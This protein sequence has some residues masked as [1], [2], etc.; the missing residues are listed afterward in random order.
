MPLSYILCSHSLPPDLQSNLCEITCKHNF[1]ILCDTTGNVKD[2]KWRDVRV[3]DILEVRDNEDFPADLLCLACER[4]DGVAYIKTTNLDG[5]HFPNFTQ[6]QYAV[7]SAQEFI[8]NSL[9]IVSVWSRR[10]F[11]GAKSIQD[12]MSFIGFIWLSVGHTIVSN[13]LEGK[14]LLC[15]SQLCHDHL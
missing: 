11:W 10:N 15:T 3:G 7:R 5:D 14:L 1:N 12:F 2:A 4:T 13:L 9:K 8:V 6:I